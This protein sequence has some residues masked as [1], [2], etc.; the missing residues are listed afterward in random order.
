MLATLWLITKLTFLLA[1][2]I[3][4]L[5][6]MVCITWDVLSGP[7]SQRRSILRA[8]PQFRSRGGATQGELQHHLKNLWFGWRFPKLTALEVHFALQSLSLSHKVKEAPS[9]WDGEKRWVRAAA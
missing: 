3:V 9:K 6:M 2:L 5:V 4:T 1:V 8:L 7:W